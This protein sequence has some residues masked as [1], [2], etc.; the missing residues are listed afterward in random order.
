MRFIAEWE[1]QVLDEF[2]DPESVT[3]GPAFEVHAETAEEARGI[4]EAQLFGEMKK[5]YPD[6]TH[7]M[8]IPSLNSVT[9]EVG[10]AL[11]VS[12]HLR[13]DN[14]TFVAVP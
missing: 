2:D 6:Q 10:R 3:V 1:V 7:G 9:D 8:F 13:L 12:P 4:A 14:F 5:L 11:K